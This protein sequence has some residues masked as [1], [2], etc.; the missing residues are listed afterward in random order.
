M[1]LVPDRTE[2]TDPTDVFPALCESCPLSDAF[3][4]LA[5]ILVEDFD[6][7]D[8]FHLLTERGAALVRAAEVGLLLRVGDE[9]R[10]AGSSS[11]RMHNLE[12]FEM[13]ST[14]GPCVEVLRTG[15]P[16]LN[17]TIAGD[18]RWPRFAAR[19]RAAGYEMV[20][21]LPMR[22]NGQIIGVVNIFGD[23][24][25]PLTRTH[26]R[27]VQALADLA[28]FALLKTRALDEATNLSDQL[29]QALD[30]RVIIEQAKGM[31]SERLGLDLDGAFT[32]LRDYS[33]NTNTRLTEV[34]SGVVDRRLSIDQLDSEG[35]GRSG[36]PD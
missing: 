1:G 30:S 14:E 25:V 7:I 3:I 15:D 5:G 10:V 34:A 19:A 21:A 26:V 33:R 6:L 31:V 16:I 32:R 4:E 13:Q 17:T 11:P 2:P 8:L 36:P 23:Q 24:A 12:L 29:R 35:R 20:H 22:H 9:L 18:A 28:S 27:A